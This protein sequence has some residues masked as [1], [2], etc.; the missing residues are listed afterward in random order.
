MHAVVGS[1]VSVCL[2]DR[3][4]LFGAMNH[5]LY[6]VMDDPARATPLFGNVATA[7]L[8]RMMIESGSRTQDLVAQILGGASPQQGAHTSVGPR[9]VEIARRVL[10][11]REV[12][13]SSEDTGG[14]MG[15]KVV[16]DTATGHVITLKV[17][18]IRED[19]WIATERGT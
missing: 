1:G 18:Q 5:F 8:I 4:L 2:W 19:D 13:V 15:R 7:E 11:R 17:H 6:P 16:F 12:A 14:L 10:N 3:R 9:N